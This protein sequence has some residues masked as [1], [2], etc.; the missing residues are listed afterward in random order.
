[1]ST[2]YVNSFA[3]NWIITTLYVDNMSVLCLQ[4]VHC[5][6]EA[7]KNQLGPRML[8]FKS[9]VFLSDLGFSWLTKVTMKIKAQWETSWGKSFTV[10]VMQPSS[11]SDSD[12]V[13]ILI[14]ARQNN[15]TGIFDVN[16]NQF[17]PWQ[18]IV[19]CVHAAAIYSYWESEAEMMFSGP[20]ICCE[21]FFENVLG[22]LLV[23]FEKYNCQDVCKFPL[24][25]CPLYCFWEVK[26]FGTFL[27]VWTRLGNCI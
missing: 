5:S 19:L 16:S 26:I 11:E 20:L 8:W 15:T 18:A 27:A 6:K 7:Q 4:L 17:Q 2:G 22:L 24:R 23:A 25:S 3:N 14:G 9:Y 1:M 10:S 13:K 21:S 12:V